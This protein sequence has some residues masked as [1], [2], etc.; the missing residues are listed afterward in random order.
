MTYS[1]VRYHSSRILTRTIG[2]TFIDRAVYPAGYNSCLED[3]DCI[4][5][6]VPLLKNVRSTL[7]DPDTPK[8]AYTRTS[9]T[10]TIQ[11]L[12]VCVFSCL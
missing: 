12:V 11:N 10:G 4:R 5:D 8:S 6:N 7:V 3:P 2:R 1:T 9:Q